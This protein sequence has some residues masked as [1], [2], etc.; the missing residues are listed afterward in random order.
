MAGVEDGEETLDA[1][2]EDASAGLDAILA[3][4]E[5]LK[6]AGREG[7]RERGALI[8]RRDALQLGLNR[9]DGPG[10]VLG[11]GLPG[12]LGSLASL[13]TVEAGF[14]SAIAAALGVCSDA[15][16]V[17]D[18]DTAAA[19]LRLLKD[20]DAGRA[21]LLL[22]AGSTGA[23]DAADAA[24]PPGRTLRR[25][26]TGPAGPPAWS[27]SC[28][29][30]G[31]PQA[32][33]PW[34]RLLAGTAVVDDLD[35]A[36]RLIAE[37]PELTAVT[38]AGDVFTAL[39]VSGGSAKAPSLLEVQAAV[40]DASAKLAGVTAE[41]ERNRFALSAAQARRAEAQDRADAALAKL[42]D[43][44]AR[45]AA[46]AER[47]GPP[48][49]GAAQRR[50][51][52]RP[53]RRVPRQGRSQH[54]GR[55]G[56]PRSHRGHG[57]PQPRRRPR[58]RSLHRGTGTRSRWRPRWPAPPRWMPASPCAARRN[59]SRPRATGPPR[60]NAPPP[61]NAV[62]ARKP[63]N[64]PAAAG[65]RPGGPPPSP[66]PWSRS[67]G[68]STSP[69]SLPARNGTAP[70]NAGN[71]WMASWPASAPA[72]TLLPVNWRSSRTPCTATSWPARS[73]GSG[74]RPWSCEASRSSD[75]AQTSSSPTT[76]RT[77]PPRRDKWAPPVRGRPAGSG[78]YPFVREE[79][80]KRLKQAERDLSA[81]GR[82]NPLALEEFAALEERHQFLS[83]QLEDL[84]ASRKDLLD[85]IK[86]VDER[87]QKVFAEAFADTAAQFGRVFARLFPGGEGR[88]VLTDPSDLLT[89][90]IEVEARPAGKK[91]KRLSLLSGGERSL[92]A[93][94]LLVAIFKARPSPVLCHGRGGG[95]P[96]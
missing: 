89:T 90:G 13:I 7:E 39:T 4:I 50:R 16:V 3:D 53:P 67:S 5:A 14:E 33:R 63:P 96:G 55:T 40:D 42:H 49:F 79:Q 84:R 12:V 20:D 46:V 73:S 34:P 74:S 48:Q 28:S 41:L 44:D 27:R 11:S 82:V 19:V 57:S 65:S 47:L 77:P 38:R 1:D 94:A 62:P 35:A 36:A 8:A 66:P 72:T 81:L 30:A 80:E 75:S 56:V 61:P 59:S 25:F 23:A 24:T 29:Q 6:A 87:V 85:I 43:S 91:I 18:R 78:G 21:S 93:V 76:A 51:R 31:E 71:R 45:L 9:K 64:G 95:G 92:T 58:K 68:S 17:Q 60:W 54:P 88:L 69:W 37:R 15:V 83:A 22:A 2:Y 52:K 10:H 26:R 86:E 70:R 32:V